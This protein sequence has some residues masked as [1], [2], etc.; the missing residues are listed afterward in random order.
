MLGW[1][2]E[3]LRPTREELEEYGAEHFWL[4]FPR[5]ASESIPAFE[6]SRAFDFHLPVIAVSRSENRDSPIPWLIMKHVLDERDNFR[7]VGDVP[8]IV[9]LNDN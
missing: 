3:S 2:S 7:L 8:R 1:R 6:P 4:M 9:Q 5:A